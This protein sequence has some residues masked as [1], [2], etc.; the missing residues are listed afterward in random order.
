[1]DDQQGGA[2]AASGVITL[3]LHELNAS[4]TVDVLSLGIENVSRRTD[5]SGEAT[6]SLASLEG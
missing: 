5:I 4:L 3:P 1:V 2:W 6:S